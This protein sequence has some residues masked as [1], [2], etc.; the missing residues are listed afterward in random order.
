MQAPSWAKHLPVAQMRI[1]RPTHSLD[2][3]RRF[4]G[5]GLGLAEIGS[6]EDP[7]GYSGVIFG[8]PDARYQLEFTQADALP[9]AHADDL[10][11]F[12]LHDKEAIGRLVVKLGAQGH[13]PVPPENPY[14]D[15][16]GVTLTDPDGRHIVLAEMEQDA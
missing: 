16:R 4:Y 6:F 3:M 14:W 9:P 10:L 13:F 12:Y 7:A 2:A 5:Q 1:A 11:V 8:L 15:A